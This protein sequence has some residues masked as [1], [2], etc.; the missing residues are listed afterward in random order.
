MYFMRIDAKQS[1]AVTIS[2]NTHMEYVTRILVYVLS[3]GAIVG[4]LQL[5]LNVICMGKMI[6]IGLRIVIVI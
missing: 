2:S 1:I 5:N 3:I 4:V 6:V